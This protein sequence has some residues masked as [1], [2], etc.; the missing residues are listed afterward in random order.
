MMV[1]MIP[2]WRP[3]AALTKGYFISRFQREDEPS[4]RV[5][6]VHSQLW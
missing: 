6:F 4:L 5:G 2:G 3:E 1:A